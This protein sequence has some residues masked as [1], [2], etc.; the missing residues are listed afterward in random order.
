MSNET[1]KTMSMNGTVIA[2]MAKPIVD[3]FHIFGTVQWSD[4][5]CRSSIERMLEDEEEPIV[6]FGDTPMYVSAIDDDMLE[7]RRKLD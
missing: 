1:I 2:E 6:L 5:D 7:L 3:N 4:K